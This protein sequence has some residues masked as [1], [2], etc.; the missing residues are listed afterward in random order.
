MTGNN[1]YHQAVLLTEAVE[2]LNITPNGVY[3]DATFGGG[4]HTRAILAALGANGRLFAFDQDEDAQQNIPASDSRFVFIA[5]NFK[6]LRRFLRMHGVSRVNGILADLG[7]SWHQ[8]NTPG[9]GF[10]IRFGSEQLDMRM[11]AEAPQTAFEVLNHYPVI[12]LTEMLKNYGDLPNARKI[13]EAIAAARQKHPIETVQQLK[14]VTAPFAIGKLPQFYARV[15]QAVRMEVN[16]EAEALEQLLQQS[17][18]VLEKG[19][20]LVIIAY[21]SVEDRMVKNFI[22]T[23]NSN[24][25]EQKDLY[26][27]SQKPFKAINKKV[28]TP[29]TEE[30]KDNPKAAS[31]KMRIA[32]KI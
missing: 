31:A 20:R 23:G 7:V 16:Q 28:I 3:V 1:L 9:R 13:A 30:I 21:H 14:G 11:S 8:F 29:T 4:S 19:G 18:Q 25:I 12:R 2:A 6:H 32:E 5:Q 22:K 24:G 10:S 27:N 15:F 26:G 17:E